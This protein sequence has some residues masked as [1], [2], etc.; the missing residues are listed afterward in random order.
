MRNKRRYRKFK[1][2][3]AAMAYYSAI[4]DPW[5]FQDYCEEAKRL[6]R[7]CK[8]TDIDAYRLLFSVA[9]EIGD[10]ILDKTHFKRRRRGALI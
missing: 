3:L 6:I 5:T 7:E 4:G 10:D 1:R 8:G 9:Y 2:M